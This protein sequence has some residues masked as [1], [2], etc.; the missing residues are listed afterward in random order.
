MQAI[1]KMI[2]AKSRECSIQLPEW[3]VGQELEVIILPSKQQG[4]VSSGK[5]STSLA[6]FAGAWKGELMV[7]E[8]EGAYEVRDELK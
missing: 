1:R 7:C 3:A 2:K 6:R 4:G 8:D 5:T